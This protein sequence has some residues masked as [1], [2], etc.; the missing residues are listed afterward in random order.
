MC[1]DYCF[2]YMDYCFSALFFRT[3]EGKGFSAFSLICR[4]FL[5]RNFT[6]SLLLEKKVY[7]I[8]AFVTSISISFNAATCSVTGSENVHGG[9]FGL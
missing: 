4:R 7:T 8:Q 1:L 6:K 5:E 2:K 3:F 9:W